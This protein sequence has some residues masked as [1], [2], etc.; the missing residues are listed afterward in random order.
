MS[1]PMAF[2][3][4]ST[5][6]WIL[7]IKPDVHVLLWYECC[8]TYILENSRTRIWMK[9]CG[10]TGYLSAESM[11]MKLVVLYTDVCMQGYTSKRNY[12]WLPISTLHVKTWPTVSARLQQL[13]YRR[14][15]KNTQHLQC[16]RANFQNADGCLWTLLHISFFPYAQKLRIASTED[17][18]SFIQRWFDS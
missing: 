2:W 16:L 18:R 8:R 7:R 1:D 5:W 15:G 10:D 9:V 12:G 13:K 17:W 11:L 3:T 6:P 4:T 14:L